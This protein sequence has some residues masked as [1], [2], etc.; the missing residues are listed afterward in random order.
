[1][2][3]RTKRR[4]PVFNIMLALLLMFPALAA[5]Q[6]TVT[7]VVK[8][9]ESGEELVG[10]VVNIKGST[11]ATSTDADGKFSISVKPGVALQFRLLG[12]NDLERKIG[13]NDKNI[14]VK[15]SMNEQVLNEVVVEAGIIQRN[16]LG[17]TGSHS[18]IGKEELKAVGNTNVLQSLKSIDPAFVIVENNIAGS[19]PN[20]MPNIEIRGQSTL[21]LSEVQDESEATG[22]SNMPLFI[23]DGFEATLEEINDLDINRIESI[24]LLKDAGSTAIYGS[25]GANG[26]VVVETVRPQPGQVFVTYNG[27]YSVSTPYLDV[28]NMMNAAEKLE[29]ERLGGRYTQALSDQKRYYENLAKVKSG[30]DTYWLKEPVQVAFSQS[31]SATLSGGDKVLQYQAGVNYK[32]N[33]GV[34]KDEY[35]KT[36]G[37]NLKLIYRGV[38]GLNIMNNIFVTGSNGH[39]GSWGSFSDF[40]Q[41]NPYY[42]MYNEDGTIPKYL[43]SYSEVTTTHTAV[44]PL[45]NA[46]LLSRTDSK[47]TVITNNTNIDWTV[48][49][50]LLLRG[51]LS[52]KQSKGNTIVFVD[53]RDSR[54]DNVGYEQKG[55]YTSGYSTNWS[56]NANMTANYRKAVAK[57][58][59]TLIVRGEIEEKNNTSETFAA[60]GFPEGSVGYPSQSYSYLSGGRPSYS[61][62][63]VRHL[64]SLTAFNYNYAYRYLLDFNYNLDGA[65]NFGTNRHFQSFWSAGAGWNVNRE[66][67][68]KDWTWLS[69]LKLRATYGTNGNMTGNYT[70]SSVYTYNVGNNFFGQAAKLSQAGN[71]NLKWQVVE[72]LSGGV[73]ISVLSNNL[74]VNFDIYRKVTDPLIVSLKQRASSGVDSYP[75]NLGYM[76]TKGYEFRINYNFINKPKDNILVGIRLTGAHNFSTYGGFNDALNYLN[77]AYK[78]ENNSNM[79]LNSLQQFHDG[80]SPTDLWA[81][82]SLGID[83][84]NGKEIFLTKNGER[85]YIFNADD[86]V[87]IANSRPD[88]EGVV[89]INARYRQIQFTSTLRYSLGAYKYNSALFN[90]VE[91][92][93]YDNVIY[94]Q[95]KRALYDRWQQPGD[96]AKFKNINVSDNAS[97]TPVSS[98]FIQRD[99][100]LRGEAFRLTWNFS[101]DKWIKSLH[102]KDLSAGVSMND[103]FNLYSIK[104]ERGIDDPFARTVSFNLYAR[105]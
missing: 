68:A 9:A 76:N 83:P 61:S 53:P 74:R 99:N 57:N 22:A 101:S 30:V 47:S 11:T 78:S 66:E 29:F 51:S 104:I 105:F 64:T 8:D 20:A 79:S 3:P 39:S 52:L 27:D 82:R 38:E 103:F 7:G 4:K 102:L 1:M 91:N 72:N 90:K 97:L 59:F 2:T 89:G 15:M 10:V 28:Y 5:A 71:P 35:R 87:V 55:R 70:T 48:S 63:V 60:Q 93:S 12:Y 45:Y 17:F 40:V 19:D 94:N 84:A 41:A 33:E 98:R 13:A 92:I 42:S 23:L 49:R 43:D 37:G 62:S 46:K 25:K 24:T 75:V 69:E 18:S 100:Y 95:D 21:N 16:K 6:Q 73:D 81:V 32:D 56:Y 86:K 44:N 26:V 96:M 36:Y 54:Y 50:D 58:N 14:T 65:T 85:T 31:H 88:I 34:M 77:E 67:F 80:N